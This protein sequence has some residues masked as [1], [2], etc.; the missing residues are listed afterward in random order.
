MLF[1]SALLR[2]LYNVLRLGVRVAGSVEVGRPHRDWTKSKEERPSVK[3][4][5]VPSHFDGVDWFA[6]PSQGEGLATGANP[7]QPADTTDASP[8]K[9]ANVRPRR[10]E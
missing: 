4:D 3:W 7:Q 5:E 10:P 2:V 9:E 6:P 1:L 8:P